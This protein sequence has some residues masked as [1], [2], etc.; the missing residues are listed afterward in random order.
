[1]SAGIA[2][3]AAVLEDLSA[4]KDE[5]GELRKHTEQKALFATALFDLERA[6]R[7]DP[8]ARTQILEVADSLLVFWRDR[9]GDALADSHPALGPL[10]AH[11]SSLLVSFEMKRFKRALDACWEAKGDA[12]TLQVAIQGLQP[13]GNRR[14]D[15]AACLYH[16]ELARLFVDSSRSEFA[17]RA[18]LVHE[19]YHSPE[20]ANE[21]VGDDEGLKHLWKE[22]IPYLD[23]F[24][25]ALEA[26]QERKARSS[27]ADVVTAPGGS[28]AVPVPDTT[29]VPTAPPPPPSVPAEAPIAV[30]FVGPTPVKPKSD[31]DATTD[32]SGR[33]L[34]ESIETNAVP[35][36]A[37]P[38]RA[39]PVSGVFDLWLQ[40]PNKPS[41]PPP[42]PPPPSATSGIVEAVEIL[43]PL[44][45]G[46]PP[47]PANF[48][49]APGS[50]KAMHFDPHAPDVTAPRPPPPPNTTPV[51]RSRASPG[52]ESGIL[53]LND[54]VEEVQPPPPPMG[55]RPSFDVEMGDY[56][57]D[58]AAQTFWRFTEGALGLLPPADEPRMD[59]RAL[60]ADGRAE[61]KKLTTWLDQVTRRFD[62]VPEAKA[63]AC[64][65]KLYLAAQLKEK[66][67]FGG[68]NQKRKEAFVA[69]LGLLSAEPLAA[70]HCAVWFE[71]DGKE[72]LEKLG[73]G[74]DV[75][76]DYLQYCARENLDPL[77][78]AVPGQFMA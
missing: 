78:P 1:M 18:S 76:T 19:A 15:F 49:P 37:P 17:K 24:F 42:P 31:F 23:E 11:A 66:G 30:T 21:L 51:P 4:L 20:T 25:E 46:P 72:T 61:R 54:I 74:L 52:N 3:C 28:A 69:A 48:T 12:A 77:D 59:R 27:R 6:R 39:G 47:P 7:G 29:P 33:P 57:P 16:L 68:V 75:L 14:V 13:A 45:S 40:E 50:I 22:L 58:E 65:V 36:A 67:L 73:D 41:A 8:D 62:T 10:W 53:D 63:F 44:P 9:S 43:E 56:E 32:P 55:S 60:S 71:L 35:P 5:L 70:G 64:L 26:E 2:R 38:P 34:V